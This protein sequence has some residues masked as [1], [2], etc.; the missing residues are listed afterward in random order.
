[1][2][3]GKSMDQRNEQ[4]I[5]TIVLRGVGIVTVLIGLILTTQTVIGLLAARSA[6]ANLPP[7]MNINIS[8]SVGRMQ[9]WAIVA[10]LSI[11]VWGAVL[12]ALARPLAGGIVGA[13]P[14]ASDPT[15][16]NP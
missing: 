4:H 8:G 12:W 13:S 14:T 15:A 9:G 2:I 3:G 10:Q 1:M 5:L 16:D 6:T 7:G 11:C